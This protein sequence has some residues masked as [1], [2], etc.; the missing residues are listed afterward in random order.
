MNTL[1]KEPTIE[2]LIRELEIIDPTET[3]V[4]T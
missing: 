2:G 1:R 3:S 4:G